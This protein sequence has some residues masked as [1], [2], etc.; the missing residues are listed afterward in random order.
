MHSKSP[1]RY[2]IKPLFLALHPPRR[3]WPDNAGF[4]VSPVCPP[5][6]ARG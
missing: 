4:Y 6:R 1:A 3:V 2:E 5:R